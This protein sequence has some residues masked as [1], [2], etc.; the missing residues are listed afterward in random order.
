MPP[1]GNP[2]RGGTDPASSACSGAPG[3]RGAR[4]PAPSR[5][6]AG[7]ARRSRNSR[8]RSPTSAGWHSTIVRRKGAASRAISRIF[9]RRDGARIEEAARVVELEVGP[10]G[11]HAGRRSSAC[12]DLR[13]DGPF[14]DRLLQRVPPEVAHQAAPGALAVR[15]EDR[16]DLDRLRRRGPAPPRRGRRRAAGGRGRSGAAA[17]GGSSGPGRPATRDRLVIPVVPSSTAQAGMALPETRSADGAHAAR[18][19]SSHW[20][21]KTW[22]HQDLLTRQ[23]R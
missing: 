14:G 6:P 15:Q 7:P 5:L 18:R 20:R 12:A 17:V 22:R 10:P 16:R 2:P 4:S 11:R 9:R 3:P 19:R 13:G 1:P 8:Q 21:R 23:R